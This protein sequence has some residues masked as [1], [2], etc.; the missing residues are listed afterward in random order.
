MKIFSANDL[1]QIDQDTIEEEGIISLDLMERAASA[2]VYEIVSRFPRNKHVCIFAGPGNNGG[3]ALAIARLLMI[4]GYNPQIY[5]FITSAQLS[6]DCQTNYERL[7]AEFPNTRL[8]EVTKTFR[9]PHLTAD[10]LVIDGLFG[11]GL[12][13]PLTGGFTSLVEYINDS[14]AYVVSI[15]IPSGLMSDWVQKNEARHI[16][17]AHITYTFQYPKLAFFFKENEPYVGHWQILD[18][19][20]KPDNNTDA[21]SHFY[22][23]E[24]SDVAS[25][26]RPREKFSDKRTYGHGLL[27]SGRYGMMGATVLAAKAAMHTGIGLTTVHAPRCGNVILQTSVPEALYEPDAEDLVC[28]DVTINTRYNALGIGP[29]LGYGAK[30]TTCMLKLLSDGIKIPAVFD[31]D[32]LHILSRQPELLD[33]LPAGSI[34]TPHVSEFERLYEWVIDSDSHR[35]QQAIAM[36]SRYNIIIVLKGA[37]T[38]IVSPKGEVYINNCGNNGM[39]TAGSGDVLTGIITSLLAQGYEPLKAAVLAVHLHGTAGDLATAENC[40]EYITAQDI[41]ANIGKAFKKIR[42]YNK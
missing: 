13:K 31:A 21:Q 14:E 6:P 29:G 9:P 42:N 1:H 39:A 37:H 35:L 34:I 36:A 24:N 23:V 40:E 38:A 19:G 11:T 12:N 18:I 25:L 22:C 20:L 8:D 16:V 32:A 33:L 27:I 3:D 4:E 30:Q 10:T 17:R 15:D 41:I 26:I 5:L 28:S 2:V 7:K